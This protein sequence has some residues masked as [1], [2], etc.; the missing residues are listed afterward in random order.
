M[1]QKVIKNFVLEIIGSNRNDWY[2]LDRNN[3]AYTDAT[4]FEQTIPFEE[5]W[6]NLKSG[7]GS[8]WEYNCFRPAVSLFRR[9]KLLV[10]KYAFEGET[11]SEEN[12]G[13]TIT[14]RYRAQTRPDLS[15]K[16]LADILPAE[17]FIEYLKDHNM[18][19][20]KGEV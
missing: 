4:T 18:F 1:S 14:F 6:N 17:E 12:L 16:D 5:F 10:E 8:G 2:V 11:F 3:V 20:I 7:M 9:R 13:K 15:I 19:Y